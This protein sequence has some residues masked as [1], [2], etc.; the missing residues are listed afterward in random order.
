MDEWEKVNESL[1]EEEFYSSVNMEDITN[2]DYIHAKRV[3]KDF[4]V[5]KLVEYH[6]LYL[7]H[8]REKC[9]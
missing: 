9:L 3:C 8:F 6:D 2:A 7:M 4:E 1:P 5:K